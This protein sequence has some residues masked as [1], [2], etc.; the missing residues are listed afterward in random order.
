MST[1]NNPYPIHSAAVLPQSTA[2]VWDIIVC[3]G[4]NQTACLGVPLHMLSLRNIV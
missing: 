2:A 1:A 4:S 3:G